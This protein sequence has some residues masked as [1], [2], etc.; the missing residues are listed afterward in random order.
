MCTLTPSP[1]LP[2]RVVVRIKR[3]T[4]Q[5]TARSYF[6]ILITRPFLLGLLLSDSDFPSVFKTAFG[7]SSVA[8]STIPL[9]QTEWYHELEVA[10]KRQDTRRLLTACLFLDKANNG[11]DSEN[12][13]CVDICGLCPCNL[14]PNHTIIMKF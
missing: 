3:S 8:N 12:K 11:Q 2:S 7:L 5:K 13:V 9:S 6:C 10:Y 14:S 4:S 1:G